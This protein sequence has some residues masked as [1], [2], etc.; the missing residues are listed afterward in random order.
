[1]KLYLN[2]QLKFYADDKNTEYAAREFAIERQRLRNFQWAF[3]PDE[4]LDVL[5]ATF[6]RA[7]KR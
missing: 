2:W 6:T 4:F 7:I 5:R 3:R 1:L